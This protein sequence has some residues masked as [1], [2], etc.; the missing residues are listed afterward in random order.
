MARREMGYA[1]LEIRADG[2][3]HEARGKPEGKA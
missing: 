1:V 3:R 2:K